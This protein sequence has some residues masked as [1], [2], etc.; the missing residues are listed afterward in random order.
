MGNQVKNRQGT[1]GNV[2]SLAKFTRPVDLSGLDRPPAEVH[3]LTFFRLVL[4]LGRATPESLAQTLASLNSQIYSRWELFAVAS[5]DTP[6]ETVA[7]LSTASQSGPRLHGFPHTVGNNRPL[8][9]GEWLAVLD[10]GDILTPYAL[11]AVATELRCQPDVDFLY[12]D[13]HRTDERGHLAPVLKPDWSPLLQEA[14]GYVGRFI[15]Y[16]AEMLSR[17][18]ISISDAMSTSNTLFSRLI[19][20][21]AATSVGHVRRVL[22]RPA[23]SSADKVNRERGAPTKTIA[24]PELPSVAFVIPTRDNVELL[25]ASIQGIDSTDYPDIEIVI[26]DNGSVDLDAVQFLKTIQARPDVQV[27]DRPGPFNFSRL[28][29]DGARSSHAAVLLFLNNDVAVTHP[30]WLRAMVRLAARPEIGVVGAKLLFPNRKIQ[31]AGVVVGFGGLAGHMYAGMAENHGGY[32]NGLSVTHEVS[33]VTG[34]CMAVERSKFESVG[35]FDDIN[36]P[37]D[38]NDIDFCLRIRERGWT[39]L[40][41]PEAT[42]V[43]H[44]SATRGINQDSFAV[45]RK[46]RE[47]FL[48]RW[49]DVIQDD[50]YFHPALSHYSH[51]EA[52]A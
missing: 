42:L 40:W 47:Y 45:Y 32:L 9:D 29:N 38:L 36:L 17:N 52:L 43:H 14:T 30:D 20:S 15:F 16:R 7:A 12:G 3:G 37:I 1:A 27:L 49:L 50:P 4:R 44:Q 22:H 19:R 33:A 26:V 10:A 39:N 25:K 31:H 18:S 48:E 34:A 35:G 6:P 5:S 11:V 51:E 41:T 13:E 2:A 21:S 28:C 24:K 23:T 46:D 8:A